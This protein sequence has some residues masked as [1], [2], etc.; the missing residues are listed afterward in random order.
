M[1]IG[2][3]LQE[4]GDVAVAELKDAILAQDD[5]AWTENEYRQQSY[6]VHHDTGSIVL[7][8]CDG[9]W[10]KLEISRKSGWHRLATQAEPLMAEIIEQHYAPGGTIIRAMAAKLPAGGR[11]NPHFDAEASFEHGHRIHVPITTNS[12]VRFMIDGR[13]YQF[14]V[15]KAYEINNRL[16][17]SVMNRGHEDRITFIFDYV[18]ADHIEPGT[19][20]GAVNA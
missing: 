18:P 13:P 14:E 12:R 20:K 16:H 19:F 8:F 1:D 11:I 10:P 15:G 2:I 7:I 6:D 17:H 9:D 3:R 4:L 5:D